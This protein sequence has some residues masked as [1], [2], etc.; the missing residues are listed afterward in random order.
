LRSSSSVDVRSD[1]WAMGMILYELL[2]GRVAF[3]RETLPE[4]C[5][6]IIMDETPRFVGDRPIDPQLEAVVMRALAK[7]PENR[8]QTLAELADELAPFSP[9]GPAAARRIA[10]VLKSE[11]ES[12][13]RIS[14]PAIATLASAAVV[15][16]PSPE[17]TLILVSEPPPPP[18][19]E[20]RMPTKPVIAILVAALA[21]GIGM[22]SFR[23]SRA[24]VPP[25]A[26]SAST[27]VPSPP[28]V[29]A[30]PPPLP[31]ESAEVAVTPSAR[32]PAP[33]PP[34][35]KSPEKDPKTSAPSPYD[36]GPR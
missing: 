25:P 35:K 22:F 2:T 28:V 14:S 9:E 6:S 15:K 13:P 4:L 27:R 19:L 1:I 26:P 36:Y 10:K 30:I 34:R 24:S 8:Q 32:P 12:V 5:M 29:V 23:A 3:R 7:A 20:N 21:L 18:P 31:V 11:R 17:P 33:A 16:L